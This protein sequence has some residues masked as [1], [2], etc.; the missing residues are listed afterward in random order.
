MRRGATGKYVTVSTM[1][2]EQVREYVPAPLPP[3]PALA[4]DASLRDRVDASAPHAARQVRQREGIE[5]DAFLIRASRHRLVKGSRHTEA[6][7][8]AVHWL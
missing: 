3:R 1:G 6:K 4:I 2:D 8:S 7:L 5:R